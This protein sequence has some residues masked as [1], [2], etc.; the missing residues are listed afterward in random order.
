MARRIR[1]QIL[2]AAVTAAFVF[3]LMAYL[4]LTTAAVAKPL[5]GGVFVEYET[6]APRQLNPLLSTSISDPVAADLRALLFDGLMRIGPE[7]LPEPALLQSLP[8]LD[9]TGMVYT[10]ALRSGVRWHDGEPLTV[11]DVL[12]TLRAVQ[13]PGFVGDPQTGGIWRNVLLERV[14][15]YTFRATLQAPLASFLS[16]A[17]FPILPAHLLGDLSPEQ[18]ASTSY[19]LQPIGTGPY[20]L[21]EPISGERALLTANPVYFDTRPFL[22]SVEFRFDQTQ[23]DALTAISRSE[24]V[25]FGMSS[26]N[27]QSRANTP[28]GAIQHAIPLAAYTTLTFNT[29]VAPL[30]D[31][32]LRRA[33]ALGT[34]RDAVIQQALDGAGQQLDTPLLPGWW[35][36]DPARLPAQADTTAAG[37]ALTSLGYEVG[38]DGL[39]VR[40]NQTLALA[41]L[42]D[43]AA[44]HVAA[45]NAVAAQWGA[46][47]IQTTVEQVE[48]TVLEQRLG[49]HEFAVALHGWQ[50]QGPDPDVLYALWHSSDAD[51]GF[52]YAG[53]QD[54]EIDDQLTIGRESADVETRQAAYRA[55]ERRWAELVPGVTLYQP[56]YLYTALGILG[57]VQLD[58]E[59]ST[60]DTSSFIRPLLL[61]RE[62]RF[63]NITGWYLRSGREIQGDLRQTP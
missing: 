4:A 9:E 55:F 33:L 56:L 25:G 61:G 24:A 35:A 15:Q 11:D 40:D 43:N 23:Q 16:Y 1:W 37:E 8:Q 44:D 34:D 27:E 14:D 47:G 42:T 2:I 46:L 49:D 22:D 48:A 51:E 19:N 7:G 60:G 52:N 17:T 10:F 13:S 29:R 5:E 58:P 41:I 36:S 26:T 18:W 62:D 28:R 63:R 45:A 3:G 38:A 53:I 12:F 59:Q 57:G 39:R 30:S 6:A 54:T 21:K 50:R 31:L 20:V 32:G